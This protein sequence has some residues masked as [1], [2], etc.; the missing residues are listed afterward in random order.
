MLKT[1][2][3]FYEGKPLTS[4]DMARAPRKLKPVLV[5]NEQGEL[6]DNYLTLPLNLTEEIHMDEFKCPICLDTLN[7]TWTASCLHRFCMDCLHKSLRMNLGPHKLLHEC[8]ACR[9]KQASRRSSRADTQFDE[10]INFILSTTCIKD[11]EAVPIAEIFENKRNTFDLERYRNLHEAKV[12]SFKDQASS[13]PK[14]KR[15]VP[16]RS[17]SENSSSSSSSSNSSSSSSDSSSSDSS[18]SSSSNAVEVDTST[19]KRTKSASYVGTTAAPVHSLAST[20]AAVSSSHY[21]APSSLLNT[22]AVS[23]L[24]HRVAFSI[25]PLPEVGTG[26]TNCTTNFT[27]MSCHVMAFPI[28]QTTCA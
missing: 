27:Y 8:P 18:N 11:D 21:T 12:Q 3:A 4:Y 17:S 22:S 15:P 10:V 14:K 6:V 24:V 9:A 16:T 25:Y 7:Q 20:G 28:F 2:Y 13:Q 5:R 1:G 19:L 23:P 26:T